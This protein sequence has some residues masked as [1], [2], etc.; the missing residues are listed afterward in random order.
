M[1]HTLKRIQTKF[2]P[3]E[4]SDGPIPRWL[5]ATALI[6]LFAAIALLAMRIMNVISFSEPLQLQTSGDEMSSLFAVWKWANDQPVYADRFRIP[7]NAVFFNWLFYASYG[8]LVKALHGTFFT[9]YAWLPTIAR[10]LSLTGAASVALFSYLAFT[11]IA[12]ARPVGYRP[13]AAVLALALGLGPLT[14][15]WA[16]TARPDIWA[17]AFEIAATAA[18][19][20]FY[21]RRRTLSIVLIATCCYAAWAFKQIN[22]Y[23]LAGTGLF[24]LVRRDYR[25]I[26]T[27]AGLL[28]P[29]WILTFAV[30]SDYYLRTIFFSGVPL[31]FLVA[32]SARNVLIFA[33]KSSFVLVPGIAFLVFFLGQRERRRALFNSDALLYAGTGLVASSLSIVAASQSG[34]GDNYLFICS[35]SLAL[36]TLAGYAVA[37]DRA[38]RRPS[39]LDFAFGVGWTSL[40]VACLL[41]LFGV[42]GKPE[43]PRLQHKTHT[44]LKQCLDGLP[45]P[46]FVA[47]SNLS[48]PWITPGTPPFVL[49]FVY[50]QE[51]AM[52]RAFESGGVGGLIERGY[53]SSIVMFGQDTDRVDGATLDRYRPVPAA[54]PIPIN[55]FVRDVN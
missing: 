7:F 28:V 22:L 32:A 53:F 40:A 27:L 20:R 29:A 8:G 39:W 50:R 45:R 13:L 48:L 49:S 17:F 41:A 35:Y 47:D 46:L 24:L 55:V 31:S 19:L 51:R 10:L 33:T 42:V 30:G 25:S 23:A 2:F 14:G 54:C 12:V 34:A 11:G 16:I 21:H 6:G 26:L 9:D 5:I 37:F 38:W 44:T 15:Y 3:S 4:N 18:F 43:V 36:F 1:I 52:G